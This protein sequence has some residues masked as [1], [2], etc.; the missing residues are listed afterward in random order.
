[1]ASLPF[2]LLILIFIVAVG[3]IWVAGIQLSRYTDVLAERFNFGAAF[4]GLILLAIATNLPEL[5]ITVSAAIQG[6]LS[7]AVGNILGGV[8][9]Q[10]AVLA[11]LDLIGVR[12]AKSLTYRAGSLALIV[13]AGLVIAVLSVVIA[14]SQM[15]TGLIIF[16]LT[17][18]TAL[19]AAIWVAGLLL[20][21]RA[22]NG[23]SWYDDGQAPGSQPEPMGHSRVTQQEMATSAGTSTA[24]AATIFLVAALITLLAGVALERS[25]SVIADRTGLSGILF[26]A[27]V[28]AL[29]TA[30]PEVSTGLAAIRMGD[31]K[32]AVSDIF[33]GNA[34]LPV[35][36]L[37]AT[38]ISGQAVLP[39]AQAADIYL[40]ALGIL[41]TLVFLLGIAFRPQ[42][43]ILGM[44]IDS[45]FVLLLYAVG[46]AG[47]LVVANF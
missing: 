35:L 14:G 17:P 3:A 28:L 4:G 24:K 29:A 18:D 30:L 16:R 13:E 23:M 19:I 2:W 38:A 34:F 11:L 26:G 36:F 21:R 8:A 5:A 43:K 1:M 20:V 27:T 39:E 33:G 10:T 22:G 37:L 6:N 41:L 25:G 44:G 46:T 42:R 15:P 40:T 9:I 47:L 12:G 31:Y 32:L 7:I 45:V